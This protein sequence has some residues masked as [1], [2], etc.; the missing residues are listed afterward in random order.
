KQPKQEEIAYTDPSHSDVASRVALA[1]HPVHAMMVTFPIALVFATLGADAFYW[2]SGAP[3]FA[4]SALWTSGWGFGLGVAAG[5]V[6]FVELLL[7]PGV[8]RRAASWSHSVAAMV[9]LSMLG[10]NW[11]LRLPDPEA[12]ALPWGAITSLL[13]AP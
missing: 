6:G 9:L 5:A 1:G 13:S 12:G 2:W 11:G 4:R 7:V 10:L 8:R 3:F